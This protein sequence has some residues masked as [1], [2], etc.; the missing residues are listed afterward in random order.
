M[1][2][3]IDAF[4]VFVA[5][6]FENSNCN[7]LFSTVSFKTVIGTQGTKRSETAKHGYIQFVSSCQSTLKISQI[8][9]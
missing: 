4:E 9:T 2:G 7:Q 5:Y 6:L 8:I 1:A 3:N